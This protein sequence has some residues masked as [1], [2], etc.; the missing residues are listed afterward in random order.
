MNLVFKE[1]KDRGTDK[2]RII[3]IADGSGDVGTYIIVSAQE[4]N[5][6]QVTT[7]LKNGF[8][9]PDQEVSKGDYIVIYTKDGKNS[10]KNNKDGTKSYFY[11][12]GISAPIFKQSK[13]VG[14]LIKATGVTKL[15]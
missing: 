4:E 9:L 14:L 8:W 2:E 7:S 10:V 11:Y 3:L 15:T 5:E 13:N 1:I 12:R 6:S